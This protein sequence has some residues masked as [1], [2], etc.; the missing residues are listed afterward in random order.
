MTEMFRFPSDFHLKLICL[1]IESFFTTHG[2]KALLQANREL[3]HWAGDNKESS[4]AKEKSISTFT[5]C[6]PGSGWELD[7]GINSIA[8][9]RPR[10][11]FV[12]CFF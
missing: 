2:A 7:E 8:I 5:R 10:V 4:P 9:R 6:C 12:F 1:E 11:F 3:W